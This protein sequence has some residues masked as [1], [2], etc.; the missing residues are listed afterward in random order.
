MTAASI[1]NTCSLPSAHERYAHAIVWPAQA[2]MM[3]KIVN[4]LQESNFNY[5]ADRENGFIVVDTE[6]SDIFAA[7]L[8]DALT[9]IEAQDTRI[10]LS[11]SK[12]PT[13][14][15][16]KDVVSL[17]HL[18]DRL[19]SRWLIS[20]LDEQRYV[21]YAQPIV[22][23][24]GKWDTVGHEFL[25][26][27]IDH[28]G[29]LIPPDT[30]FGAAKDPQLLFNLDR[31]ARINAVMTAAKMDDDGDVF[32]NF[33]PGSVYD[34][35]V[36]LRTT[37]ASAKENN[38]ANERIVIE[39]V[40]SHQ[41]DDTDHLRNIVDFY[42]S[43]GFRIALDDFGTGFNNFDMYVALEPDFIK[44]DK[45]LTMNLSDDDP[46]LGTVKGIVR[47][48]HS[49]DI[50]VIAEGIETANNARVVSDCGVDRMQ[51]YFF[52]YPAPVLDRAA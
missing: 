36:C 29:D 50:K 13:L 48:A 31:T 22:S 33:L 27:G 40:E 19:N 45:T 28:Q 42:R 25:F 24:E 41:I 5:D 44:L 46:R 23:A 51:G 1:C 7:N 43:A 38:I 30:L 32:I 8:S 34:P 2:H 26:R 21:S 47:S 18:M 49:S 9:N 16:F 4:F 14:G 35:N 39:I 52:G 6:D 17:A 15:A 12:S 11:D 10:L 20:M 3:K 37:V